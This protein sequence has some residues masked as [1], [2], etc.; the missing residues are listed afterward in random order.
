MWR[1]CTAE[2]VKDRVTGL[3]YK[4]KPP[5]PFVQGDVSVRFPRYRSC[6]VV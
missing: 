1:C 2:D 6:R 4:K 3:S 5:V